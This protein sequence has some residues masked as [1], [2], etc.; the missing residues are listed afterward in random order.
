[1][2]TEKVHMILIDDQTNNADYFDV[3]EFGYP[4]FPAYELNELKEND[5]R[6]ERAIS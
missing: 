1:M 4:S 3:I 2:N 5:V 6:K